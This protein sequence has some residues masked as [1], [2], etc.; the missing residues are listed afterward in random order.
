MN[1][2]PAE[3]AARKLNALLVRVICRNPAAVAGEQI[4]APSIAAAIV[5][6]VFP[7]RAASNIFI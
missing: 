2:F 1:V 7:S 4:A 6:H 3:H 5:Q